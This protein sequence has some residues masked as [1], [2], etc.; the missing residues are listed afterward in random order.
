MDRMTKKIISS[1]LQKKPQD[2]SSLWIEVFTVD[3]FNKWKNK[4][5]YLE[6]DT[7][8]VLTENEVKAKISDTYLNMKNVDYL[9]RENIETYGFKS[10]SSTIKASKGYLEEVF[11]IDGLGTLVAICGTCAL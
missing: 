2:D 9:N 3:D 6:V 1:I 5:A 8:K 4:D 7:G 11:D 10:Y